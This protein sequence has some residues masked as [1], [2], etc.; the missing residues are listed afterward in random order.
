MG[1][2]LIK[3]AAGTDAVAFEGENHQP[4]ERVCPE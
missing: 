2:F 3:A 1:M 4:S